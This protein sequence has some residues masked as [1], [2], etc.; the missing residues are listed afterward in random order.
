[1]RVYIVDDYEQMSVKA[2]LIVA[3]QITMKADSI[4]GLC[5]GSTP[6]GMYKELVKLHQQGLDFSHVITFNLD[7]YWGLSPD[8]VQSYHYF[9]H[10]NFFKHV[11]VKPENIHIPNGLA[12][13]VDDECIRYEEA[14]KQ[15][16]GLDLQVLGI[17]RNGH[18]GFN[19]PSTVFIAETHLVELDADT[20]NDNARFFPSREEVPTRAITMGIKTIMQAK[21]IL[22]L[23]NGEG[24]AHAIKEAVTGEINPGVPASILQLHPDCTF[25]I[26]KAAAK[27]L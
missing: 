11:N 12:E 15:A 21:K 16:N 26:D 27:Y 13:N 23:A 10:E 5:T 17:G 14:I 4:L 25:I 19:E 8:N 18:I 22:L 9:M 7:E 24:K 6:I 1:M 20:I 2:A 3:G